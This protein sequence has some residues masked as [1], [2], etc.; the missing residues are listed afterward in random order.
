[1]NTRLKRLRNLFRF[2]YS[3]Y[4]PKGTRSASMLLLLAPAVFLS[5][6]E[7]LPS[8]R[9]IV[10]LVEAPG[11]SRHPAR[12]LGFLLIDK[13]PNVIISRV[14]F[15]FL[16]LDRQEELA[17]FRREVEAASIDRSSADENGSLTFRDVP[18]G[19]YWVINLDPVSVGDNRIIWAH[20][21]SVGEPGVPRTVRL[22]RSNAALILKE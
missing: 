3:A 4:L 12:G 22:Q 20:P 2:E 11:F 1:M 9:D 10:V 14:R 19:S 18:S 21:V 17:A 8:S 6:A 7:N 16:G 13:D 15:D 5:C